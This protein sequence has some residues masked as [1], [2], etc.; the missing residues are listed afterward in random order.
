MKLSYRTLLG[1]IASKWHDLSPDHLIL[2]PHANP[3]P[4]LSLKAP[5][6]L[7]F[8]Q[9]ENWKRYSR[10]WEQNEQRYREE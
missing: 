1:V 9:W 3:S 4:F 7:G 10:K 5:K 8:C 2:K 6:E